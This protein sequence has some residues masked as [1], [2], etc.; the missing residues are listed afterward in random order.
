MSQ[1]H[2]ILTYRSIIMLLWQKCKEST[3]PWLQ[4]TVIY[5]NIELLPSPTD[6]SFG[7]VECTA[8]HPGSRGMADIVSVTCAPVEYKRPCSC[9]FHQSRAC[10]G[11]PTAGR[12]W[13]RL[14]VRERV[15]LLIELSRR[16]LRTNIGSTIYYI[17][18]L[19]R[20]TVKDHSNKTTTCRS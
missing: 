17:Y 13:S 11:W 18:T 6:N 14:F 1:Y 12:N 4:Y 19:F 8:H 9:S 16:W 7:E 10:W 3:Q 5:S 2:N 15:E 20:R